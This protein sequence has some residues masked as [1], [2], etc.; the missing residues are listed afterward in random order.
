[1]VYRLHV[2]PAEGAVQV[3]PLAEGQDP[4][5]VLAALADA[6]RR[7]EP[8][9]VRV[10]RGGSEFDVTVNVPAL[11]YWYVD[12]FEGQKVMSMR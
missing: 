10:R 7:R 6:A 9:V 2:Q 8:A 4:D 5:G 11:S 12:E 3:L 1:M